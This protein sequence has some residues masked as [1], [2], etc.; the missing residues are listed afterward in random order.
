M[1]TSSVV[2]ICTDDPLWGAGIDIALRDAIADT[3]F[4][5]VAAPRD[6]WTAWLQAQEHVDSVLVDWTPEMLLEHVGN[7][8]KAVPAAR[9]IL[10]GRSIPVEYAYQAA[11]SGVCGVLKRPCGLQDLEQCLRSVAAN[12]TWFD[13]TLVSAFLETRS[14]AL[15]RRE[16]QLVSLLA[17]G[18]K[19]K[20]IATAL[21]ISEGTVKVYMSKLFDKLGVKDRFELALY[22]LKNML[23]AGGNSASRILLP[24]MPVATTRA[25]RPQ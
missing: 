18:L 15:T 9:I 12:G 14:V 2:A 23:P 13:G 25:V 19:N 17:H 6:Q 16:S 11:Q 10:W 21:A 22:G 8:R 20:E 4:R 24:G 5:V 1:P 3:G 7:L